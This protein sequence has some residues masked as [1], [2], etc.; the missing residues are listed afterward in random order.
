MGENAVEEKDILIYDLFGK[1][2]KPE[3]KNVSGPSIEIDFSALE[4]GLYFIKLNMDLEQNLFR[5]I[6]K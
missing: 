4:P 2:C 3:I 6:K 1:A 5:I